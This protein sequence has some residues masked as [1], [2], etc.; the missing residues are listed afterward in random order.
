L[1]TALASQTKHQLNC[2]TGIFTPDSGL[3]DMRHNASL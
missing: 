1:Y 2:E 3:N